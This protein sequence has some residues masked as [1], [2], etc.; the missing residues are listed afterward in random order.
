[1]PTLMGSV[2]SATPGAQGFDASVNLSP[3]AVA[4]LSGQFA[5]CL[6]YVPFDGWIDGDL[7]FDEAANILESGLALMPIYPYP[8]D[9]WQ[10]NGASGVTHGRRAAAN[11]RALGFPDNVN[12]WMDLEGIADGWPV[13]SVIDHCNMWFDVVEAA[14]YVP[15]IYVGMPCGLTADQLFWALK[16]HHYWRSQSAST[17]DI[18]S[19]GYQ[20]IQ[21]MPT[22][23]AGIEVD[24]DATRR[25]SLGG[26]AQWLV[27]AH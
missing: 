6:R 25:D 1:M 24:P 15:G 13:Q 2:R 10:P 16:F 12:L 7:T 22:T 4:A 5:F 3:S 27:L 11:A 17:P 19:R 20:M 23:V 14:G 9:N 18:P 21:S 26:N 8:G